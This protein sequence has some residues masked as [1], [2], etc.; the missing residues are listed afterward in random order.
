[1]TLPP[2]A[3][4]DSHRLL[5]IARA[6]L[7]QCPTSLY[8]EATVTGSVSRGVADGY[9]DIELNF[10]TAEFQSIEI[11]RAWVTSLAGE[12][13]EGRPAWMFSNEGCHLAYTIDGVKYDLIWQSWG[14]LDVCLAP[15]KQHK[16]PDDPILPWVLY[17]ALPLG[18]APRINAYQT[19]LSD[20][21]DELRHKIINHHVT[22][23][24][25][26]L[27][28]PHILFAE[29]QARRGQLHDLRRRQLM[30]INSILSVLFAY[31]RLWQPDFKWLKPES[32]RLT[33][34]P[35][36]LL[37]R[38]DAILT[39]I[40]TAEVVTYMVDL[41]GDTLTILADEF[42]AGDLIERVKSLVPNDE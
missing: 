25:E 20:Y 30:G 10:W 35:P 40:D 38:I 14:D 18:D 15:L 29:V 12:I 24:R 1:M 32:A 26:M 36:H 42:D 21:P 33:H 11:Y 3:T 41:M 7:Q 31:N 8:D 9:S 39:T 19:S 23:W 37:E 16:L 34:K 13:V 17:H 2:D 28:I 5:S 27:R 6:L 22:I 4:P